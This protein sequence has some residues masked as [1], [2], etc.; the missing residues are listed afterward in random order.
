LLA[1]T[2][3][4]VSHLVQ[5]TRAGAE[6]GFSLLWAI[7]LIHLL[8]YPFFL[9][10]PR[11]AVLTGETLIEG[12]QRLGR[13]YLGFFALSTGLTVFTIQ[14]ALTLVTAG[15]LSLALPWQLPA[16]TLCLILLV[17]CALLLAWGRYS[18]LDHAIKAVIVLLVATTL[19]ATWLAWSTRAGTATVE[20]GPPL[21]L[22]A[23]PFLLALMGWMPAPLEGAVWNSLWTLARKRQTGYQATLKEEQLDFHLGYGG[24]ALLAACFLSLGAW[25]M[26]GKGLELQEG[27]VGFAAQLIAI[28]GQ[29]LGRWTEP[30]VM[31]CAL[32]TMFSTTLTALDAYAR[33]GRRLVGIYWRPS[34]SEREDHG[35]YCCLLLWVVL[36]ASALVVPFQGAMLSLV[37]LATITS[38]LATPIFAWMNW[39]VMHLAHVP[40]QARPTRFMNGLCMLSGLVLLVLSAGYGALRLGLLG[41]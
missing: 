11:Y 28:Y 22:T 23:L 35:R 12:Y 21:D 3:V 2:A 38:F 27:S 9:F 19:L 15:L 32:A 33:V 34:R 13:L 5:A 26:H 6:Y 41:I 40:A 8:K 29:S 14:A 36:G 30:L 18:L 1:A 25:M 24:C 16:P 7:L 4:G 17:F 20:A 39:R 37:D 31:L 10:G